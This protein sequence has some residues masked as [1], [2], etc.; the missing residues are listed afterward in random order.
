MSVRG[1]EYQWSTVYYNKTLKTINEDLPYIAP[2][3]NGP[4]IGKVVNLSS[5]NYTLQQASGDLI[6]GLAGA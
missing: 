3:E 6:Y 1:Q 2:D 4:L 5:G